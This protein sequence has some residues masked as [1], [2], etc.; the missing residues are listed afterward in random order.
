VRGHEN[1]GLEDKHT[2]K[3]EKEDVDYH[4]HGYS[5][6]VMNDYED[7]DVMPRGQAGFG[8]AV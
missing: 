8:S 5:N 6:H 4:N 1:E 3:R 2:D 7:G